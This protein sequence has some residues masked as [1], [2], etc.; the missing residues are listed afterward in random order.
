[1]DE[2]HELKSL[3]KALRVL[4]FINQRGD[5]T[6][7]QVA[8]AIGLP[9]PTAYR[10]METLACE[11]YLEKLQHSVFYR[12]TSLVQALA[13]GFQDEELLLEL[14]KPK[15]IALGQELGWPITL[16]T[17]RGIN[18][19]VRL[20]TDHDS[21]LALERWSVGYAVPLLDATSGYCYLAHCPA[22]EREELVGAALRAEAFATASDGPDAM[23]YLTVTDNHSYLTRFNQTR[24]E[25]IHYLIGLVR[26]RGFCNIE[27]KRYP[28]GN[29]GVPLM[30]DGKPV[31]GLVMRYIKSVMKNTD[32]IQ[33]YYVPRLQRLAREITEAQAAQAASAA[34]SPAKA[35]RH[36]AEI[37]DLKIQPPVK[38][39]PALRS[40]D[41]A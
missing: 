35:Q 36:S 8:T 14:A 29:V 13:A 7:S 21:A 5:A 4:A 19:V 38:P 2:R 41:A 17:P 18:M 1:M 20:N 15:I 10:I 31:G 9:R 26:E 40:V 6:V 16:Y 12:I 33:S 39:K 24:A 30:L 11:G 3:K 22:V 34:A 25:E 28:E 32:R 37:L 23:R 27:F